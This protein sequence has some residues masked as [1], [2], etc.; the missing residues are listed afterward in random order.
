MAGGRKLGQSHLHEEKKK[1]GLRGG[2]RLFE[3]KDP[4]PTRLHQ[5]HRMRKRVQS[6]P[7][8]KFHFP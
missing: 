1:G 3:E 6:R 2:V 5:R 7:D 4:T 8:Y